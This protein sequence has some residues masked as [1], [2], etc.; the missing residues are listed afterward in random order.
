MPQ[1]PGYQISGMSRPARMVGGDYFDVITL[2]DGRLMLAVADVSGKGVPAAILLASVRAAVQVEAS[3]FV[4]EPLTALVERLNQMTYRD[5]SSSMFVT[6]IVALLDPASGGLTYCNA[7]HSHPMLCHPPDGHIQM[8]D[9][10]GCLLGVMPGAVFEKSQ[11]ALTP[12]SV[13]VM[14]S[15]GVTDTLNVHGEAFGTQQLS[16]TINSHRHLSAEELLHTIDR[17]AQE[18]RGDAEP[19]DDF[20]LLIL[21]T[22]GV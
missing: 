6:M 5:T 20:T 22:T 3:R 2:S 7:G 4:G 16:D 9:V 13:L 15:D 1:L 11:I 17:K 18:F 21:K 14:Y 19:F 12:G 10:G 8:L